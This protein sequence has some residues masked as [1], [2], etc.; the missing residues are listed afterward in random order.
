MEQARLMGGQQSDSGCWTL[1]I[2]WF[3]ARIKAHGAP[4]HPPG[5]TFTIQA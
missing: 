5:K 4:R 3:Q 2:D 1:N